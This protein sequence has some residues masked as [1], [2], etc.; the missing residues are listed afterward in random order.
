MAPSQTRGPSARRGS[1]SAGT[2]APS[3]RGQGGQ[4]AG[5]REGTLP[6]DPMV[7]AGRPSAA[8]T[9]RGTARE[10][11]ARRRAALHVPWCASAP[12]TRP[13]DGQ[14]PLAT[15][16]AAPAAPRGAAAAAPA[17][18]RAAPLPPRRVARAAAVPPASGA[19]TWPRA[20]TPRAWC[21]PRA[22]SPTG[23]PRTARRCACACPTAATRSA[24]RS[25]PARR[26]P[27]KDRSAAATGC[28]C[29]IRRSPAAASPCAGREAW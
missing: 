26:A 5:G 16:P 28:S 23:S 2:G 7:R 9:A 24:G 27:R 25:A 17:A 12:R 11:H 19:W 13:T 22:G 3:S 18:A 21:A 1:R 10:R 15:A 14:A 29:A 8:P 20:P 4:G 6:G